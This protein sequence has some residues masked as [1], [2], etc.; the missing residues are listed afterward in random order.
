MTYYEDLNRWT[1]LI[2]L[3]LDVGDELKLLTNSDFLPYWP[4]VNPSWR[5][6]V[7]EI[8]RLCYNKTFLIFIEIRYW[9]LARKI[10]GHF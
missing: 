5:K 3:E 4:I 9:R 7:N 10:I 8:F 6:I 2:F 1:D